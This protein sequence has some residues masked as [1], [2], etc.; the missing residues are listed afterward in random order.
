MAFQSSPAGSRS[1]SF[2]FALAPTSSCSPSRAGA[3]LAIARVARASFAAAISA[4]RTCSRSWSSASR[5]AFGSFASSLRLLS[6][7]PP[8]ADSRT[9]FALSAGD[10]DLRSAWRGVSLSSARRLSDFGACLSETPEARSEEEI[11]A[12]G[13]PAGEALTTYMHNKHATARTPYMHCTPT[14]I[15]NIHRGSTSPIILVSQMRSGGAVA[16]AVSLP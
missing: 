10:G 9:L 14:T 11:H 2:R 6:A 1:T 13:Q 7:P 16:L 4:M 15:Y 5:C 8:L 3:S 12:H